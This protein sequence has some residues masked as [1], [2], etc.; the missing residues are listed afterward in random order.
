M[1]FAKI[2]INNIDNIIKSKGLSKSQ[3]CKDLDINKNTINMMTDN[4]GIASF[5]LARI[6][7]YLNVS[8]DFLL[9]R[10]RPALAAS[11]PSLDSNAARMLS[12]FAQL[13]EEKQE[14]LLKQA[15][16]YLDAEQPKEK[17]ALV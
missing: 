7:D 11:A 8:V 10:E 9:G 5:T 3:M 16:M 2:V 4:K 1:Y 6:A 14:F 15:E 12:M 17:A 13:S